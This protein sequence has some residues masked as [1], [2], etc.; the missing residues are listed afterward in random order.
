MSAALR[1]RP[2]AGSPLVIGGIPTAPPPAEVLS[3]KTQ[4][5]VL[6][7]SL[8]RKRNLRWRHRL[9]TPAMFQHVQQTMNLEGGQLP[10]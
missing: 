9:L 8:N 4:K 2:P 3:D 5:I 10:R 1:I 6:K 7:C